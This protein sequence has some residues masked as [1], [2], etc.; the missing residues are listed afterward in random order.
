VELA[1]GVRIAESSLRFQTA[2]SGGPGGQNVNKLNTKVE[3]WVPVG[4]LQGLGDAAA[5]RLRS[6]AG[7]RL[8]QADEIHLTSE[9]SR[10]QET[11]R[12]TVMERLRELLVAA[13]HEPKKR[14][15][16]RPSRA[17]K[18]RRL[19]SKRKR[20]ETKARRRGSGEW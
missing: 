13:M 3:L 16:T 2:R 15:K 12:A 6:A 10:S 11:N 5:T 1:P 7:R 9:T 14:R 20:G 8:T 19:E 17:A 4:A 18:L